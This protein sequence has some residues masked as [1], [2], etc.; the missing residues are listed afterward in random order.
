MPIDENNN[1]R[2]QTPASARRTVDEFANQAPPLYSEH[3]FDQLYSELDPNG[4]RT[5]GPGSGGPGTP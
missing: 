5:P 2:D 1:I 4:Y 3:Q